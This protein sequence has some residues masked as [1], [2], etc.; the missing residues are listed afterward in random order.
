MNHRML[1][2]KEQFKQEISQIIQMEIKDPR[3]QGA[4]ITVMDVEITA[5]LNYAKAYVSIMGTDKWKAVEGLNHSSGFIRSLLGKRIQ[6]KKIP[7][8]TFYLDET[9]L[10]ADKINRI[11]QELHQKEE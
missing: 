10:H 2:L 5:D 11:L 3:T 8:I 9:A 7:R 1:R 6:I 4:F